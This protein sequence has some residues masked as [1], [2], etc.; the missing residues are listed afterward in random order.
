MIILE[1]EPFMQ[2]LL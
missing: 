2:R 1:F